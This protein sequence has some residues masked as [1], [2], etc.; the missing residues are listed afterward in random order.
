MYT[1]EKQMDESKRRE[2]DK[3][4][5]ELAALSQKIGIIYKNPT[6]DRCYQMSLEIMMLQSRINKV[7]NG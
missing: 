6:P 5:E 2:L 1:E 3:V 7:A 4:C